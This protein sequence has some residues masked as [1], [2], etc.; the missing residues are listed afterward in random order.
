MTATEVRRAVER[1]KPTDY[2]TQLL[3]LPEQILEAEQE[4]QEASE[5]LDRAREELKDIEADLI[6]HGRIQGKNKEER[7]AH[8]RLSTERLRKNLAVAEY[9]L[10]EARI[11]LRYHQNRFSAFRAVVRFLAREEE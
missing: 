1:S 8:L 5:S 11:R 9:R 3:L 4:C 10:E 6:F 2:V 7:D